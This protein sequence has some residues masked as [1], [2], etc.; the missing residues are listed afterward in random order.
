MCQ[1][2]RSCFLQKNKLPLPLILRTAAL[3]QRHQTACAWLTHCF[4]THC[5]TQHQ[6]AFRP[7]IIPTVAAAVIG[8]VMWLLSECSLPGHNQN[9][10]ECFTAGFGAAPTATTASVAPAKAA[11]IHGSVLECISVGTRLT[12]RIIQSNFIHFRGRRYSPELHH[13]GGNLQQYL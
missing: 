10:Q 2:G 7:S 12:H 9:W 3:T 4:Y 13:D 5:I 11:H 8:V 6:A 1:R